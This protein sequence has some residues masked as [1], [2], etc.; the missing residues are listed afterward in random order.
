MDLQH[1]H[2][3]LIA[4]EQALT[5]TNEGKFTPHKASPCLQSGERIHGKPADVLSHIVTPWLLWRF[6]FDFSLPQINFTQEEVAQIQKVS[7][8]RSSSDSESKDSY[9]HHP[10]GTSGRPIKSEKWIQQNIWA[11]YACSRLSEY[12]NYCPCNYWLSEYVNYCPQNVFPEVFTW[13][14]EK[15]NHLTPQHFQILQS[16]MTC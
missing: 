6:L 8:L 15:K 14:L 11:C 12:V 5:T 7:L 4:S 13:N 9:F 3:L 2:Y 10:P 16:S 1:I